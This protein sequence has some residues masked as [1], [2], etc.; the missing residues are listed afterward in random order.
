MQTFMIYSDTAVS[1]SIEYKY[2]LLVVGFLSQQ[3]RAAQL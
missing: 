1:L 3:L 2:K